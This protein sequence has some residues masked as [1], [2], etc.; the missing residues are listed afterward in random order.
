MAPKKK[1][2]APA[3]TKKSKAKSTELVEVSKEELSGVK[4]VLDGLLDEGLGKIRKNLGLSGSSFDPD[5]PR[6]HTGLL[7]LD[8]LIGGGIVSGGWYTLYGGEQSAKTTLAM[9]IKAA[10][11]NQKFE[12]RASYWDYEGS[13]SPEY[14]ANIIRSQGVKKSLSEVFGEH[15]P[16][17]GEQLSEPIVEYVSTSEGEKFFEYYNRLARLLP[18]KVKI[19]K[20]YYYIFEHTKP[21]IKAFKGKYSQSYLTKHNKIRV[22]AE[23]GT[24][25]AIA[26]LDSYPAMLSKRED[27]DGGDG[28][29]GSQARM[30]SDQIKRI[31]GKMRQKRITIFGVNQVRL[32]PMAMGNPEYEPGGQALKFFCFSGDTHLFTNLG[33]VTGEEFYHNPEGKIQGQYGL[34]QPNVYDT[35]GMS[36]LSRITTNLGNTLKAKPGHRVLAISKG[37]FEP[38]WTKLSSMNGRYDYYVPVQVGADVWSDKEPLFDFTQITKF[39]NEVCESE[40]PESMTP[41]LAYVLGSLCGDGHI[42]GNGTVQF[43]SQDLDT[44][45]RFVE[46]FESVFGI[47]LDIQEKENAYTCGKHSIRIS[48]FLKYLGATGYSRTKSVPWAIRKA[49]RNSTLEFLK[50]LFDA[51]GCVGAKGISLS[52]TSKSLADLVHL[53]LL[54]LGC[55]A[56]VKQKEHE[57]H[58]HTSL[59]IHYSVGMSGTNANIFYNEVGLTSERKRSKFESRETGDYHNELYSTDCLPFDILEKNGKRTYALQE[60][61]ASAT[62]RGQ[63]YRLRNMEEDFISES[64]SIIEG[65]RTSHE[66]N[67]NLDKLDKLSQFLDFTRNANIYWAKVEEVE[68]C[69]EPEMTYDANMPETSTI[70]TNGIVSHNSDVRIRS[71]SRAL[72]GA[73]G[74]FKANVKG[75]GAMTQEPSVHFEGTD[76]YRFINLRI[77]KNKLGGF[78][79]GDCWARIWVRDGDGQAQGL[80]PVFDTWNFLKMINWVSG[81]RKNMKF[82]ENVPLHGAKGCGWQEFKMLVLGNKKQ[83]KETC[84]KLGVKAGDIRLWCK[85]QIEN[86]KAQK[87]MSE[88]LAGKGK[89]AD[90]SDDSDED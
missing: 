45:E 58:E 65:L 28:S 20:K 82:T 56:K 86:G 6:L 72:S 41:E 60:H 87:A 78:Q 88:I 38:K 62:G 83:I 8:V 27:S 10:L 25:Q 2:K 23:D 70:V 43:M 80:D 34:E 36:Q 19:G 33:I 63:Y 21:N 39:D 22:P 50:G 79:N 44:V 32:Q 47:T 37:G 13:G 35:M 55:V 31:K 1:E 9:T 7:S 89:S 54:N 77:T 18:D 26:L 61:F 59:N 49:T 57:Y 14:I 74:G 84:E 30:F 64:A 3:K 4:G 90:G 29:L 11:I 75:N 52:T 46:C 69:L 40:L 48:N 81:T 42:P 51:D 5:E 53:M 67:K 24:L 71:S 66:R 16:D 76:E 12:G 15:D 17:T 68:H 73:P 85:K